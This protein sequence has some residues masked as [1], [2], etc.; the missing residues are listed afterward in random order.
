MLTCDFWEGVQRFFCFFK[1]PFV[2]VKIDLRKKVG[3]IL[4][5]VQVWNGF[6]TLH[7]M[8]YGMGLDL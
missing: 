2:S 6:R 8:L 5:H 4:S 3:K 7:L 1:K